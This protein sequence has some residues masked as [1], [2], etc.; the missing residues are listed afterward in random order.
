MNHSAWGTAQLQHHLVANSQL[1]WG[2]KIQ[3]LS[4]NFRNRASK[5]QSSQ[6]KYDLGSMNS[7]PDIPEYVIKVGYK[8]QNYFPVKHNYIKSSKCNILALYRYCTV[9]Y[10]VLLT[11]HH[12]CQMMR[13][14]H[15]GYCTPRQVDLTSPSW[16]MLCG[17]RLDHHHPQRK[18]QK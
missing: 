3:V 14:S 17:F 16:V 9:I 1:S 5:V 4:P 6:R 18:K 15:I 7:I 12:V 11:V 10:C 8:Q 13:L 2:S